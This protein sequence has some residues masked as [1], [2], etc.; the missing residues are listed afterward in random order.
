MRVIACRHLVLVLATLCLAG[1]SS[2]PAKAQS[3]WDPQRVQLSRTELQQLLAD[4]EKAAHSSAYSGELREQARRK[5]GLIST[6]LEQGDFQ[7]GDQ[8]S[9]TVE[10]EQELSGSFTVEEGPALVLPAMGIIPLRGVLRSE[11]ERHL[12]SELSRFI[13]DPVVRA[14][15]S[16]R[17][18]ITGGVSKSGFYVVSTSTVMSELLTLAGGASGDADLKRIRVE[19]GEQP[20]W[21]GAP[22][23]QAV[24]EGRT[25]D[26][27]SIRAG[28]HIVVP[29]GSAGRSVWAQVRNASAVLAPIVLI[30]RLFR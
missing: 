18:L 5:A 28:D 3:R 30:I 19:R 4:Y 24:F 20:I 6:R 7:V 25:L 29:Q 15:S 17:V 9:M 21:T 23:Q 13:R 8:I 12:R 2:H 14:R 10:G 16:I 1:I 22:L 26:Q 27:M 11:L